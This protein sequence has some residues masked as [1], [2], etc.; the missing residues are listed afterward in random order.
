MLNSI[1]PSAASQLGRAEENGPTSILVS[2]VGP[3]DLE[4]RVARELAR[5]CGADMDIWEIRQ[6]GLNPKG[7]RVGMITE[8]GVM[9]IAYGT[10]Y[11][12]F[13]AELKASKEYQEG[14]QA[15]RKDK[16]AESDRRQSVEQSSQRAEEERIRDI[17][18]KSP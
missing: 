12:K 1:K 7:L 3:L 13:L 15:A 10:A 4:D 16:L 2:G 5:H 8:R 18:V 11:E 17:S 6:R 9:S 14:R